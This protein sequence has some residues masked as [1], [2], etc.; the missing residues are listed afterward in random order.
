MAEQ[1]KRDNG[2][3]LTGSGKGKV[4]AA[5]DLYDARKWPGD[6]EAGAGLRRVRVNGRWLD[7]DGRRAFFNV[8]GLAALIARELIE[9]GVLQDMDAGR[10]DLRRG[11]YVRLWPSAFGP[12]LREF[13]VRNGATKTR[14]MSDPFQTV[15][16]QWRILVCGRVV[17]C[18]EVQG[19]D[20]FGRDITPKEDEHGQADG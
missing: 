9:G 18:D 10:P 8:Q 14:A 16:G 12:E 5:L 2:I 15:D 4:L 20:R 11:Q 13:E 19:L 1:R 17:P 6:P 3:L 7:V